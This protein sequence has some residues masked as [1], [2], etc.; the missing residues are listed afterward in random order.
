[1]RHHRVRLRSQRTSGKLVPK[2]LI[3]RSNAPKKSG[4]MADRRHTVMLETVAGLVAVLNDVFS[5]FGLR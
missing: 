3:D 1:M 5:K 2:D 4:R